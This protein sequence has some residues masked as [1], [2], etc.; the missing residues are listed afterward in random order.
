MFSVSEYVCLSLIWGSFFSIILL[1][2]WSMPL[3]WDSSVTIVHRFGLFMVSQI[4]SYSLLEWCSSS[5]LSS[6]PDILL[7]DPFY[8]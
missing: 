1:K 3:T 4:F 5:T 2:N 7:L 6:D 8:C